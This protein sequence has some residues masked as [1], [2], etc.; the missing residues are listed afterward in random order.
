MIRHALRLIWNRKRSNA[1]ILMEIFL[2]FLVVFVVA[3]LG[4]FY[5]DNYR[6][7]LGYDYRDVWGLEVDLRGEA[8][9]GAGFQESEIF[10]RLLREIGSLAPVEA[11]GAGFSVPYENSTQTESSDESGRLLTYEV[12]PV[13][14]GIGGVLK[15]ETVRGRWF[16]PGDAALTWIPVVIDEDLAHAWFGSAD[17]VGRTFRKATANAKE[18][19]V[20]GVVR[21]FRRSGELSATSNYLLELWR[22]TAREATL[23]NILI[24]LRPGTPAAFEQ[25]LLTR[26]RGVAR[27]ADFEVRTLAQRR[28]ESFRSRLVPLVIG[29]VVAAFLLLMVGLGLVGVLWQNLI[30]R[31]R[32]VGLRRAAGASRAGVRGQIL[33]EQLLISTLG[34]ALAM[35]LA[36][37]LPL[38]GVTRFVSPEVLAAGLLAAA[39]TIY[40]LT[41]VCALYP[42]WMASRLPPA[43]A[44]RYE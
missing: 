2:S 33:I 5:W 12:N 15:I 13:T 32:E 41:T 7:P 16:E 24:R 31:T 30:R 1:L 21:D 44:L 4:I 35:I 3:T 29:L 10:E 26:L 18:R 34:I 20:I 14:E 11:V 37:Q 17:P 19:R 40:L 27:D 43:E 9:K 25:E 22:P 23:R 6:R 36:L 39:L 28:E 42:S 38:F 8:E